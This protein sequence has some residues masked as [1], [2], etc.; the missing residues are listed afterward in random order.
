[1][2]E[3]KIRLFISSTFRDMNAERDYLNNYIFPQ[4]KEYCKSRFID[5]T[6]IDLR[7][8]VT[9]ETSRNGLVLAS[10]MEEVD[11][12]RPF[13]VGILGSRYGWM[14]KIEELDCSRP[15]IT[16]N[17]EWLLSK[18][19][20]SASITEIEMD[21]AVLRDRSIPHASFYIRDD[22]ETLAPEFREEKGSVAEVK[23]K[24][25]K[26]K[27]K[28]QQ[29]YPIHSYRSPKE[30][31]DTLLGE[32]IN[33]I[34][35]EFPH[36]GDDY[37]N[38]VI[39]RHEASLDRHAF[40][41]FEI[42][43]MEEHMQRWG[44]SGYPL[45]IFTGPSG[46]GTSNSIARTVKYMRSHYSGNRVLY[47]DFECAAPG[48]DL[49]DDF[50]E[51]LKLDENRAPEDEW[52]MVAVDNA[53]LLDYNQTERMVKWIQE[54]LQ[55]N[56]HPVF[57]ASYSVFSESM[58]LQRCST[59]TQN[60]LT[61]QM[62][63]EMTRNFTKQYGKELTLEQQNKIVSGKHSND[64]TILKILLN[65]LVN[66]GSME[67][68]NQRIDHLI[69]EADNSI[70]FSLLVEA[71]GIFWDVGLYE[72]FTQAV[73]VIAMHG[74]TGIS[75]ADLTE[76]LGISSAEWAVVRP[77]ILQFC[78]D[79]LSKF[80]F[81]HNR[82]WCQDVKNRYDTPWIAEL[83][84]KLVKWW[85][86]QSRLKE[87]ATSIASIYLYVWHLPLDD[88]GLEVLKQHALSVMLSPD[89]VSNLSLST[90]TALWSFK[91]YKETPFSVN[92]PIIMGRSLKELSLTEKEDYYRRLILTAESVG[93]PS[94]LAWC[95][96]QLEAMQ[97]NLTQQQ[98]LEAQA[99]L[100][101]GRAKKAISLVTGMLGRVTG[102]NK[103]KLQKRLIRQRAFLLKNAEEEFFTEL[104][105]IYNLVEETADVEN[106]RQ[107]LAEFYFQTCYELAFKGVGDA[108]ELAVEL[109]NKA[110]DNE[111][112]RGMS[113]GNPV[114]YYFYMAAMFIHYKLGK[115]E[116]VIEDAKFAK[117]TAKFSFGG[118]SYQYA[119]AD[120]M[121]N[122]AHLKKYGEIYYS[123]SGF[124]NL[125]TPLK[126][127]R[128]L[129][130]P[131]ADNEVKSAI[132]QENT[133]YDS[134][135]KEM[136]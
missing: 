105:H 116:Q 54:M 100:A 24:K 115:L 59:I 88:E 86:L 41:L 131:L 21:Y 40:T 45:L 25:L 68:L 126:Y 33:M 29:D 120:A 119:R 108:F 96:R 15:S 74:E 63:Y 20:D 46:S 58:K 6:P 87:K 66:F 134:L 44:E 106:E 7:W 91:W 69:K 99:L 37:V 18:L 67:K 93:M 132:E 14:P 3:R 94:N 129:N 98:I 130:T 64:P 82:D 112:Y 19:I 49:M 101:E 128:I 36:D 136:S 55:T 26:L 72:Q 5:F 10:C 51:F 17:Q 133:F 125:Y 95:F 78:H 71:E 127:H 4:V 122:Y 113:S 27:I 34:D 81:V 124:K 53:S 28:Q 80:R 31:G 12:S 117:L 114:L 52:S 2:K 13:F 8:G 104:E 61:H 135:V 75:E 48:R 1:M 22:N 42:P 56:L 102:T 76:A 47:Y 79:N 32:L 92:P 85:A 43:K 123:F 109:Y 70:F 90:L 50:T 11:N 97:S 89:T 111:M 57:A 16:Q 84:L 103:E 62:Q 38:S 73:V 23:L 35:L 107:Q 65:T 39:G 121:L 77:M 9:E 60:G 110:I 30:L 118:S 83:G